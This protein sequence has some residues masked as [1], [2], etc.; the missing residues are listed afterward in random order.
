MSA[1]NI[2][3]EP[4][5][6][7]PVV[8]VPQAAGMPASASAVLHP[9]GGLLPVATLMTGLFG[10]SIVAIV[11][12]H[13]GLKKMKECE[14]AGGRFDGVATTYMRGA[15]KMMLMIGLVLGYIGAV[16]WTLFLGIVI[17]GYMAA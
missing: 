2:D 11:L 3:P 16:I 6:I 15:Q 13:L 17:I 8:P 14:A 9:P 7:G 12:G 1:Q 4:I 5:P 10:I